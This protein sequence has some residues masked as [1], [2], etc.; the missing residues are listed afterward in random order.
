LALIKGFLILLTYR[1]NTPG[2]LAMRQ[3]LMTVIES[4][5]NQR[6]SLWKIRLPRDAVE[7]RK[8]GKIV[9]AGWSI[10][11]LFG[12]DEKG[13]YMDYYGSHRMTNDNHIRIYADGFCKELPAIRT[14]RLCSEDPEE[15]A[16]LDDEYYAENQR[17]SRMLDKKGFGLTGDEPGGVQMNRL[18]HVEQLDD[19]V[20][21]P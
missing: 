4:K 7:Q 3:S 2:T 20:S 19:E 21:D 18:L 15:D 11:Y 14:F 12:S 17:V 1:P 9:Q 10:W 16:R 8:R 5:F 13:D 6:F